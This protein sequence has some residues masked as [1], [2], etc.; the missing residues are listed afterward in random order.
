MLEALIRVNKDAK[1]D[2]KRGDVICV[3]LSEL[4]EWGTEELKYHQA[5]RWFDDELEIKMRRD[6]EKTGIYPVE[7]APY[8]EFQG[9]VLKTRSRKYL[10]LDLLDT[11]LIQ[12]IL[13]N[14]IVVFPESI[15]DECLK[16]AISEKDE[17]EIW[18]EFSKNNI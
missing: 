10:N 6:F 2:K 7:I 17:K 8:K 1:K 15:D 3:K 18:L 13:S 16:R 11:P 9:N 14:D 4:A 12:E 5:V